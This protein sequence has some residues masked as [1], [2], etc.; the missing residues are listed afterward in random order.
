MPDRLPSGVGTVPWHLFPLSGLAL[1]TADIFGDF[2]LKLP[3]HPAVI[4][5]FGIIGM[6]LRKRA[7]GDLEILAKTPEFRVESVKPPDN[8]FMRRETAYDRSQI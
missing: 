7:R 8:K 4:S 1:L 5:G 3:D 2:I 6:P